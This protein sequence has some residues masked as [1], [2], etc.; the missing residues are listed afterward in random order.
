MI[1]S[2]LWGCKFVQLNGG[3]CGKLGDCVNTIRRSGLALQ[4]AQI[5]LESMVSFLRHFSRKF[6][7]YF[8]PL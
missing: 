3:G 8:Y 2:T 6:I 4:V 1:C 7:V 5:S